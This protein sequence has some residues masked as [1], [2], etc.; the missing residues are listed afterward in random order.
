MLFFILNEV[1]VCT[2]VY[3]L[4]TAGYSK[5]EKVVVFLT[6]HILIYFTVRLVLNSHE[7]IQKRFYFLCLWNDVCVQIKAFSWLSTWGE[8]KGSITGYLHILDCRQCY[9]LWLNQFYF[10]VFSVEVSLFLSA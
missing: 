1:C 3:F 7:V 6:L 9:I 2:Y 4:Y 5:L 8:R 10:P